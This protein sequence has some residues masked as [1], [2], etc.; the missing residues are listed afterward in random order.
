MTEKYGVQIEVS[1]KGAKATAKALSDV[2]VAAKTTDTAVDGLKTQL[3]GLAAAFGLSKLIE[4]ADA[5]GTMQARL[6]GVSK[7]AADYALVSGRIL[8]VANQSR[9]ALEET[10][11]L[12]GRLRTGTQGLSVSSEQLLAVTG[13]INKTF[14]LAGASA[15]AT[16]NAITQLSQGLGA[17]ALRGEE[18]NSVQ[19]A[20][21]GEF[22]RVI[23]AAGI[24][25]GSI[26]DLA[27]QGALTADVIVKS[28]SK[29][30]GE[31]DKRFSA[32]PLTVGQ[33]FTVLSNQFQVFIGQANQG[34]GITSLFASGILLI[35]NNLQLL[36]GGLVSVTAAYAAFALG[37]TVATAGVSGLTAAFGALATLLLTNPFVTIAA[38]LVGIGTALYTITPQ[39][40][41]FGSTTQTWGGVINGT[42]QIIYQ[43]FLALLELGRGFFT[44]MT[45][46]FQKIATF[47]IQV[48]DR[49]T[50]GL[51]IAW[52]AFFGTATSGITGVITAF[53]QWLASF[54]PINAAITMIGQAWTIVS[55][56]IAAGWEWIQRTFGGWLDYMVKLIPPLQKVVDLVK[57][58]GVTSQTTT[59]S[60]EDFGKSLLK[61]NNTAASTTPK[62]NSLGSAVTGLGTTFE[63]EK[64]AI[65]AMIESYRKLATQTEE[66]TIQ[67]TQNGAGLAA[68]QQAQQTATGG[69]DRSFGGS[70]GSGS[71][72][73]ASVNA[74]GATG[75]GS[76]GTFGNPQRYRDVNQILSDFGGDTRLLKN[77]IAARLVNDLL[78]VVN[79][80]SEQDLRGGARRPA[81]QLDELRSIIKGVKA[82]SSLT[83]FFGRYGG[84]VLDYAGKFRTG[85]SFMVGGSSAADSNLVAFR[86]TAGERVDIST[87]RQQRMAGGGGRTVNLNVTVNTPDADS[88]RKSK[89]QVLGSFVTDVQ[90]ALSNV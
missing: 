29:M 90:R 80:N 51:A 23:Q 65:D 22:G 11:N 10:A 84:G 44:T 31:L 79:W 61:L 53:G 34:A 36:I 18:F 82:D 46:G 5:Y 76:G 41:F 16:R 89:T 39:M 25:T 45:D 35:A 74:G 69:G 57:N 59:A 4:V 42:L 33:A 55:N 72:F 63:K 30:S 60:T 17:G 43:S 24:V 87:P 1:E 66:T 14:Q 64:A 71:G 85:G 37:T 15:D 70:G 26:R 50:N 78:S 88:F 7:D 62:I 3:A 27:E 9:S 48:A 52:T 32:L 21:Q 83:D 47:V 54:A 28:F 2:G 67:V 73:Q 86:A 49:I 20:T 6:K 13:S 8:A 68:A 12:Y 77:P 81:P 58:F 38:A 40:A 56:G 75:Q 19:E